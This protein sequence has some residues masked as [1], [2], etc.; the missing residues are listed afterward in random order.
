MSEQTEIPVGTQK[1]KAIQKTTA[2]LPAVRPEDMVS[3]RGGRTR[4]VRFRQVGMDPDGA[5]LERHEPFGETR[6]LLLGNETP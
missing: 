6:E 5:R 2:A 4:A 3:L 1:T